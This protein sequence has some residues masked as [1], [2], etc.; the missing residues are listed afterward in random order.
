[1]I[2]DWV[3][4]IS[5]TDLER[6][7]GAATLARGQDYADEGRVKAIRTAGD[8]VMA[9]VQGTDSQPYQ[10]SVVAKAGPAS[11]V[12]TCTCPV[13]RDCKHSAALLL[14]ARRAK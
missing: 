6:R 1:M 9:T 4:G 5:D 11:L 3:T 8:L 10:C 2:P 13:R 12:A 7:F 14:T